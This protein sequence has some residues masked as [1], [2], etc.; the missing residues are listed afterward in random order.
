MST[1]K[2]N[3]MYIYN[4]ILHKHENKNIMS[5]V[6]TEVELEHIIVSEA[7]QIKANT[8]SCHLYVE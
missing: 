7:S 5:L 4:E 2:E 1:N 8:V 3:V 6:T